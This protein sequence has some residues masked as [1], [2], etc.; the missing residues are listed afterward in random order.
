MTKG[1]KGEELCEYGDLIEAGAVAVSD[2]GK[3]VANAG[4]MRR[5]L[6]Y[7]RIFDLPAISHSEEPSLSEGGAMNEG[8]T[9]TWMGVAGIPAA[10]EETAIFRDIRLAEMTGHPLHIAHVSTAGSV[11]IIRRAKAAGIRVTAETAPHY[12]TLTDKACL[13]YRTEAKMNPPLRTPKDVEAVR[14]GLAD[15][16]LDAVATDHAP[17]A[18]VEKDVEFDH[19]AFGI[20][21]LETSLPLTLELVRSGVLSLAGAVA[22][23]TVNPARILKIP[24]GSLA[25]GSPADVTIIDMEREWVVDS[26]LFKTKGRNTPFNGLTMKGQAVMTLVQGIKV[27]SLRA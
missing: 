16:T 6:E 23:M 5:V 1:L 12:F 19:A 22:A 11:D 14:A 8:L 3:P 18:S 13:G 17:H 21:G 15:G 9:A 25:K 2:D 7:L 26:S 10:A 24:G 4:V 27:H 20:V